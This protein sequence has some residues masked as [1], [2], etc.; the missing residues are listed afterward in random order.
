MEAPSL[1]VRKEP[2]VASLPPFDCGQPVRATATSHGTGST[3]RGSPSARPVGLSVLAHAT[4][5]IAL[6]LLVQGKPEDGADE[7]AMPV[8]MFFEHTAAQVKAASPQAEAP[9]QP[10]A[11]PPAKASPTPPPPQSAA[12]QP[13]P[14]SPAQPPAT[15]PAMPPNAA[16]APAATAAAPSVPDQA[17]PLPPPVAPA[18][19]PAVTPTPQPPPSA[20]APR[21]SQPAA[22]PALPVPPLPP[23]RPPQRTVAARPL[24]PAVPRAVPTTAAERAARTAAPGPAAASAARYA[25][26]VPPHPVAGMASDRPPTY[27]EMARRRGE[28]GRVLLR[29]HV[30]VSGS[31]V[32]VSVAATSGYR[33]LDDA[34]R[35]AVLQWRFVPAEQAGRPV[36]A[37][38]E[39]PVQFQLQG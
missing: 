33:L 32:T 26:L 4:I 6:I 23:E 39:V 31:P 35:S 16:P 21:P 1:F 15:P 24:A 27:P 17:L 37:V 10:K 36:P 20:P 8:S 28:Q 19:V 2:K 9:A 13:P 30:D 25:P 18:P 3:T 14:P 12:Q 11:A 29:V 22:S 34:A 5:L 38:A 7:D